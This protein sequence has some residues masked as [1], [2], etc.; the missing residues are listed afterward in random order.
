MYLTVRDSLALFQQDLDNYEHTYRSRNAP[1]DQ[2]RPNQLETELP[3]EGSR[4][5]RKR[6][7]DR[8]LGR[9]N[10]LYGGES[11]GDNRL[12]GEEP[13]A[14]L[15]CTELF[16][17]DEGEKPLSPYSSR[18]PEWPDWTD[19]SQSYGESSTAGL[20]PE[21]GDG[22]QDDARGEQEKE[23]SGDRKRHG[24]VKK[25]S[26][27]AEREVQGDEKNEMFIGG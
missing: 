23:A 9:S 12:F 17:S 3:E 18:V 6:A 22:Y 8:V 20:H 26:R 13:R 14:S 7:A 24:P 4:V 11:S 27:R 25:R 2:S 21:M 5:P 10:R 1:Q 16:Q 15:E 19:L